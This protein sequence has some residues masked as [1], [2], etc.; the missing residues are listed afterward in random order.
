MPNKYQLVMF[1][2]D[3]TLADSFP[4]LVSVMHKISDK[5]KLKALDSEQMEALRGAD[6]R[7]MMAKMGVPFWKVPQM[8]SYARQLAGQDVDQIPMFAG[9]SEMLATLA[10]QGATLAMVSSNA[11]ENI[12]RVLGPENT[13]LISFFECGTSLSGKDAHIKRVLQ[14]SGISAQ[15]AIL[16]GD[17]VR[18]L[19]AA[20]KAGVA[21]GAVSWGYN[22][23]EV[24]AAQS[25][26]VL[27]T[28][29]QDLINKLVN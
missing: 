27:F 29:M 23:P 5:Y 19:E 6:G 21:S 1:D 17:E 22:R 2:F 7:Q 28:S 9:V 3:G 11:V 20:R 18:D 15:Q 16:I 8:A 14:Q 12:Q 25:P 24:L 4:W 13:A 26:T 10:R